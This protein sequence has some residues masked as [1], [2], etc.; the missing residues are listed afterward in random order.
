M[1]IEENLARIRHA[2]DAMPPGPERTQCRVQLRRAV[3][4]ITRQIAA[5]ADIAEQ[6]KAK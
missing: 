5:A 3:G 1:T 2:V 6:R 4:Q